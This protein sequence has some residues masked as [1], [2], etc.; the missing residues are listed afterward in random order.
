MS[1]VDT[2]LDLLVGAEPAGSYVEVRR[3]LPSGG[4]AQSFAQVGDRRL[5]PLLEAFGRETDTYVGVAPRVR[6]E[7]GRD[8][9][10]RVHALFVDSDTPEA[11]AALEDFKPAASMIVNSGT[12]Q[13]AYWSI[14]PPVAPGELEQAIRRLAHRLGADMRATDA[15][16]IL[17]PPGTLNHKGAT[18]RPVEVERINVE[19][20]T[21]EQ[22]VDDLPEP[23]PERPSQ[24]PVR[25][26][27]ATN[28]PLLTI[29]P[30]VYV[31]AL[32]GREISP[33]G[34]LACPL[35]DDSD[36]SFHAWPEPERGW[37]CFGCQRGGSIYDLG[38]ALYGLEPRGASFGELR[39]RLAAGLLGSEVA[40]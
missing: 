23:M 40:A 21:L 20:Y 33:D 29:P 35:H 31:E 4:M 14:S 39:R 10:E 11:I 34:K 5:I 37:F 36:P 8:A 17:R 15:A 26:P 38:A 27:E 7:G 28:D 6:Q 30:P 12:G 25:P 3:K 16:R 19:V 9:I 13:H 24:R 18:P 1:A 22:V 32:T 2:Y